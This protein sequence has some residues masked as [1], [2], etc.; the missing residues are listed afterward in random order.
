MTSRIK[1][2]GVSR[3]WRGNGGRLPG[4]TAMRPPEPP[5]DTAP[6]LR[7]QIVKK[8]Q[9]HQNGAHRLSERFADRLVC[10]RY[11]TDPDSGRRFTTVEILVEERAATAPA[12]A[13]R[14]TH[15][16]IR[17]GYGES[18]LRE[19]IKARGGIWVR[20]KKLWKVPTDVI[21]R[22]KLGKRVVQGNV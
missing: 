7:S 5:A 10:V 17:I 2:E 6:L 15:Q 21:R 9:P 4:L 20:D 3:A 12:P 16:L 8:I 19:T 13:A 18:E 1:G 14:P 11:R 22:L